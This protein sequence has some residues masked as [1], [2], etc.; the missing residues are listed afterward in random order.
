MEA[1]EQLMCQPSDSFNPLITTSFQVSCIL[2]ISHIFHLV[3][4]PL[5]QPGPFAQLL[6]GV[7]LGPSLLS[8]IQ[9]VKDFFIQASAAKYYQFFSF[10]CRMLF[11]FSIG[12][13]TDVPY[14]RRNIRVVSIVAGGGS[15][16]ACLF[17]GPFFW[18]LIK[19]F[20]V[21]KERFAFYLLTLTVLANSASPIVIRMIAETK[22]DTADLGRMAIYSS[23]VNEMSCVT[24][25]STLKAFSSF[26][27]FGGA[28]LITLVTVAVIFVNKY[29]SYFFNKRNRNNRFV[30]NKEIFVIMFLLTCLAL[31]AEWVGYTAIFCCFLVG[32]MF[33]REGKTART[34]L[35]KLTYSV[36]T[37]ILPV[38]FGYTGFQLDISNIF[39]KLTLALTVLMILVSAGTRIVG[40]LA[41]CHYLMIPWNE[42]VILS[43]LLCLKG[44][45]DLILINTNPNPNMVWA[46]DLHDFLLTVVVLNTLIIGPVAAILLNRE[47][48]SA[49]YPTILEILNPESELR[50]LACVYVPRHVSGHVSLISA[51]GGCPTAPIKPYM[52]H[53]VELPKKRKSKLMYHQLEDGD[54]YSDE[55]EYGG[56]DVL[57]I[58]DALDAFISET[59]IL[60]HQSK[61][62][63]SF[64]TINEDVCNGAEDLRV[65]IIFLPFHKHQRIDGKMENSMEE[66]RAINQK[67]L[68]HAPCSVGIFVDRGQTGFQQ[69]HGSQCVQNIAILFF[70]GP[71]DRE[72]LACS[73]RILMHSKVN[74]TVI[75]FL[76]KTTASRSSNSW[77][78]DASQKDE[79][80]I[81]AISNIGTENEIDNAFV[82]TFYNRYV[83]QGRAGFVEKYVSSG[84]ETV[85]V[86]REIA[87][88]YSL[89]I[90]GKGGRGTCPLTSG[91]SDWE[92][93][94]ELGL[95][96]DLLASSELDISGSIL[97]IQRHRHSEAEGGFLDD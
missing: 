52:V 16:L 77:I 31:Y 80:V 95:V 55:E 69:P 73:K 74:L 87:D 10:V 83:A 26:G 48:S 25:V 28:I 20:N 23:L 54:Q 75:R 93:C 64:L 27:R 1:T 46:A 30:S 2:V 86:L 85:A 62:V 81:M 65:C 40:T 76:H 82:E 34:L 51:L 45:Y 79:E 21:T 63:A 36:N 97:V 88:S 35:H 89:F 66:I 22:F 8:R 50:I 39:N 29:L 3:L 6:A 47:E 13:E 17:G 42:S 96:G 24:I 67:V 7:V 72:A 38:Y 91:M 18:L 60:V 12:L 58:N 57:E 92:E 14:L 9:R 59:K 37:F 70:G 5:G 94:P 53:L 41:A 78:N 71:D 32:L 19:V 56:N 33:P 11:M 49:Q 4:K 44:N 90:V 15:I 43:L 68:R 84:Q 61:I